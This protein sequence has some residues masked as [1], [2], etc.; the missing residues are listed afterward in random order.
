MTFRAAWKLCWFGIEIAIVLVDY[1]FTAAFA[2]PQKKRL[3][4]ARWL[5]RAARRHIKI[6]S[7]DYTSIGPIPKSGLLV[8]NHL[9]YLDIL[10]IAALTPA[11]FVSKAEVRTWPVIGWLTSIAGTLYIVRERR[12]HVGVVNKEIQSALADGALVVV[13]PEG[14]STNG[15]Q[16]L[17]FRSPLLDPVTHGDHPI[18]TGYIH[19]ELADGDARTEVCYWGDHTFFP[20]AA[21]LLSKKRVHATMRFGTFQRT[22][23]DRKELAV[24]LRDAVVK[25]KNETEM[26]LKT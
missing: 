23:D 3:A 13:F 6:Y 2:S 5:H 11:V 9:G 26:P 8:S 12:T 22:T 17:P 14:S 24:Q 4:R 20:H 10:V 19:Y 16:I 25:L 1:F 18:A 15:E 21:N 7:C